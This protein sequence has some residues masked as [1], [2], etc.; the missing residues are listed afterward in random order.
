MAELSFPAASMPSMSPAAGRAEPSRA[1]DNPMRR[2]IMIVGAAIVVFL[3]FTAYSVQKSLQGSAQL[4]KVQDVYFPVL[5]RVDASVVM[6]DKIDEQFTQAVL[7]GDKEHLAN[8]NDLHVKATET[9]AAV[10]KMYAAR[11]TDVQALRQQLDAYKTLAEKTALAILDKTN[12]DAS[13][14][15]A[16]M[17][18][19]LVALRAAFTAFRQSSYDDFANT[20]Q[21]TQQAARIS[22]FLGIALGAMNLCFMGVL[23]FFIRNN[24]KMMSVIAEQNATLELRVAE[25]TAQLSQKTNDIA[26]MLQNMKLGVCTVVPGNRIHPEYSDHLR[27]ITGCDDLADRPL[28]PGVFGSSDLGDDRKDQVETALSAIVGEELMMFEM[29]S[30]LL[31]RETR[32]A[33]ADGALRTVQLEWS[34]IVGEADQVDKVLLILQDVTH[35]RELEASSAQQREELERISKILKVSA[36]RFNNFI[37]SSRQFAA[38]CRELITGRNTSDA[39]VVASLFRSMHTIKGNARTFEFSSITDAAHQAEQTYDCLRKD[40]HFAWVEADLLV[41]LAAVENAIEQYVEVNEVKLGRKGRA[42]DFLTSR[43]VFLSPEQ[44]A[45]LK[46]AIAEATTSGATAGLQRMQHLVGQL[47]LATLD[48]LVSGSL[49]AAE[50]LAREL[51]KP[52]PHIDVVGGDI[53]FNAGFAEALKSSLMHIV[54]NSLDH[55]IEGTDDRKQAGKPSQGTITFA[56]RRVGEGAELRIADDGRGLGLPRLL[57]IG[58][59]AGVFAADAQPAPAELASLIFHSGLSTAAAVTQVSGRGVGMDAVRAFL[60][61]QHAEI[62]IELAADACTSKHSPFSFVVRIPASACKA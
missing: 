13:S 40:A 1:N 39:E 34:P 53:G 35:L 29:N 22:L 45:E 25:R 52:T 19:T 36:G 5:E 15:G 20:L 8:A 54:R 62:D 32:L 31:P 57:E 47:G 61:E 43:G 33:A 4:S 37:D 56:C 38:N 23:V 21:S 55:G 46:V 11:G 12:A 10:A 27:H 49:D 30:H 6:L 51:G 3:A 58:R 14:S 59:S 9:L 2:I 42:A 7:T 60:S 17:N 41:E 44:L 18:R 48:R 16:E 26:A 24:V 50:S 28:L